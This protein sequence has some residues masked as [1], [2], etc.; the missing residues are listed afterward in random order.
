MATSTNHNYTKPAH[1]YQAW[2]AEQDNMLERLWNDG[3]D[4]VDIGKLVGRT[5]AAIQSRIA[6][7]RKAGYNLPPAHIV[8]SQ[9]NTEGDAHLQL[10]LPLEPLH[11][12][13]PAPESEP[14]HALTSD[15]WWTY[16][17]MLGL[18]FVAGY[19]VGVI[20]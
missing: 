14:E 10:N 15:V 17:A 11:N 7:L 6:E 18:G 13:T 8:R 19:I 16:T 3:Y 20:A 5:P 1:N 9:P 4:R 12:Q 2:T